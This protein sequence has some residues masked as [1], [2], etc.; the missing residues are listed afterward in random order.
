MVPY[1][2]YPSA[3][4]LPPPLPM[5]YVGTQVPMGPEQWHC[6]PSTALKHHFQHLQ[7]LH[8]C[9]CMSTQTSLGPGSSPPKFPCPETQQ[10][11][12]SLFS[13]KLQHHPGMLK[14]RSTTTE[15]G[16]HTSCHGLKRVKLRPN[17]LED[18]DVGYN[19]SLS[20]SIS[21]ARFVGKGISIVRA[22]IISIHIY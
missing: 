4:G 20:H 16:I 22:P 21:K 9:T 13:W 14:P 8:Q 18:C 6:R 12:T 1:T 10:C 5:P 3:S 11:S 19:P 7:Q 15:W 2:H 17:G